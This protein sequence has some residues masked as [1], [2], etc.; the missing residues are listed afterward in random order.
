MHHRFF[1]AFVLAAFSIA[2]FVPFPHSALATVQGSVKIDQVSAKE[3]GV[4]TVLY[5]D[6]STRTSKDEGVDSSSYTFGLTDFGQTT[7]SVIPPPGMSVKISVYRSDELIQSVDVPQYSF[8]LY[9]NDNYR[10]LIQYALT[11]LGSLGITSLPSGMKFRMRGPSGKAYGGTTPKTFTNL[12]A[13]R[14]SVTLAKTEDCIQPAPKNS[15]VE[16]EKRVT[17]FITMNCEK[18][19]EVKEA[20]TSRPTKRSLVEYAEQRE[21]RTRGERK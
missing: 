15:V 3:Y 9:P 2:S 17:M 11:R 12:P 1:T 13:G 8:K 7:I 14:Y 21:S 10:F 16:P 6:G 4:C 19:A 20:S 18:E 5:E